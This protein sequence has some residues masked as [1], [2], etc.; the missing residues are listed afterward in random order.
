MPAPTLATGSEALTG[1]IARLDS[2]CAAPVES[3]G[4]AITEALK[5][6]CARPDL[7]SPLQCCGR[8]DHYARHVLHADPA[9]R[10]TVVALVWEPGQVTPVH[11]H[12]AWCSY[13]VVAG[14]LHEERYLW[15]R[16]PQAVSRTGAADR[17]PGYFCFSHAGL[18]E[19][20][21]LGNRGDV[22]AISV[23]VY[24]VD[25]PRIATHVNRVLLA[26]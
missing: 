10:Y 12:Y 14:T 24:G 1:L 11:G 19:I 13:A 2:A 7:L 4:A 8:N 15:A 22:P 9:G 21:R 17:A 3:M 20:H 16:D 26:A 5:S 6:A 23:H 18:D 25:G